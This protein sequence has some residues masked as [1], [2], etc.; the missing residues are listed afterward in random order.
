MTHFMQLFV[1]GLSLGANYALIALGFVI[2]Y[3]STGVLNFAQGGLLMIGA[4]LAFHLTNNVGLEFWLAVPV[5][6]VCTG[7]LG[8]V[9]Q[10]LVFRRMMG[11]PVFTVIM[12]TWALLVVLEQIPPQLWG[13]DF[14]NLGDPWGMSMA[15]LAGLA[16]FAIDLWTLAFGSAVVAALFVFF[17]YS[18]LGIAM[19]ATASDQEAALAQGI[20][21][22]VVF[23]TAW[24]IA[25][26]VACL[27]GV[28]L[29]GGAR[30]IS[31]D[32]ASLAL[33]AFPAVILGGLDSPAGAV[34][35]GL[36]LGV[37]E[38]MTATFAPVH[39]SWL[40]QNFHVVMPYLVLVVLLLVRPYGLFGSAAVRRV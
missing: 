2:I 14:L 39:A 32:I 23:A 4:Y 30:V 13:Y 35:G 36:I 3:K 21:P 15:S 26:A 27:S 17:R 6:M 9:L 29:G 31:P 8:V 7:L 1:A 34:A 19:R 18:R 28:M 11:R 12:A 37:A 40:G 20:S 24:F 5:A 38:V 22:R 16:V 10:E 25:G 33:L